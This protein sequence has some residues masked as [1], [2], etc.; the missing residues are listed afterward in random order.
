MNLATPTASST[1]EVHTPGTGTPLLTLNIVDGRLVATY[2]PADLDE[3][4]RIFV[5]E[6]VRI[7]DQTADP[8]TA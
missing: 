4:A 1:I 8:A 7:H 2:D 5:A 6:V 3:A